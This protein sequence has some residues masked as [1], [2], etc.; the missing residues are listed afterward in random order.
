LANLFELHECR[1]NRLVTY[2]AR[3]SEHNVEV[4]RR[5]SALLNAGDIESAFALVHPSVEFRELL[6]DAMHE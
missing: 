4:V 5:A 3:I 2:W 6:I 1:V